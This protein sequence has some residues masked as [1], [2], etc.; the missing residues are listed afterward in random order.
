MINYPYSF[1]EKEVLETD[2]GIGY[3]HCEKWNH[4]KC[5]E[6]S[7]FDFIKYSQNNKDFWYIL[8]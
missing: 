2:K 5:N 3:D 7:D 4:H 8:H 6:L 1:N